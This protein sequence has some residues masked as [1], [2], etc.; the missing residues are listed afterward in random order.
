MAQEPYSKEHFTSPECLR[1]E[2][3]ENV[4]Y[5]YEKL[6]DLSVKLFK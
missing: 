2:R 5:L 1:G 3:V 6:K 4:M